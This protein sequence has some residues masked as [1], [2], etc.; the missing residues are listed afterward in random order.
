MVRRELRTLMK[1]EEIFWRQRSRV[2]WLKGSDSNSRFFHE[3]A[4]Q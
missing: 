3:C 2:A 1:K 4:S